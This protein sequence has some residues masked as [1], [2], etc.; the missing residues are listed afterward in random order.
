MN[1]WGKKNPKEMILWLSKREIWCLGVGS[2]TKGELHRGVWS[3]LMRWWLYI[4]VRLPC[5]LRTAA[6]IYNHPRDFAMNDLLLVIE[7]EH[8]NGGHLCR[9]TAGPRRASGVGV[10]HQVCVRVFLHEHVLALAWTVVGFV[11]FGR[12]DPVPAEGLEIH[13]QGVATAAGLGGVLVAVQTKVPSWTF[14]C[15]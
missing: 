7:V 15:L 12:N 8:V 5:S 14:G 2:G 11:A 4:S 6:S 10:L 13:G 1:Y 9:G 3:G